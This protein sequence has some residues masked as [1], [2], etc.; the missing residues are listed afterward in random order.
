MVTGSELHEN[1]H[2]EKLCNFSQ[3][4]VEGSMPV[5]GVISVCPSSGKSS[6]GGI[7]LPLYSWARWGGKHRFVYLSYDISLLNNQS[8]IQ[9]EVLQSP[10]WKAAFPEV[11]LKTDKPGRTEF[12]VTGGGARFNTTP[13]SKLTG[14]HF[15]FAVIDDALKAAEALNDAANNKVRDF[16]RS[17]LP[18]RAKNPK[19][20]PVLCIGQRLSLQDAPE[21]FLE[22][23]GIE[24]LFL[25]M[26]FEK[27]SAADRGNS[28]ENCQD[29]RTEP[30]ELMFPSRWGEEEV[31]DLEESLGKA[32]AAAQYAQNPVS[33]GAGFVNDEDVSLVI[34]PDMLRGLTFLNKVSSWDFSAGGKDPQNHSLCVGE[35]WGETRGLTHALRLTG[36]TVQERSI[37]PNARVELERVELKPGVR[38]FVRLAW[39]AGHWSYPQARERFNQVALEDWRNLGCHEH[40]VEAKASGLPILQELDSE[41]YGI[42]AVVPSGSKAE[43]FKMQGRQFRTKSVLSLFDPP[44]Q[45]HWPLDKIL[46]QLL[47][48]PRGRNDDF[49]DTVSQFLTHAQNPV[50]KVWESLAQLAHNRH[51]IDHRYK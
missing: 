10:V 29:P 16:L 35:L 33:E 2:L 8:G 27:N 5:G 49:V 15:D 7:M 44:N 9:I 19:H 13:N 43:R 12:E 45:E 37:N 22:K 48:F 46:K 39:V 30:G 11:S 4:Y 40:L 18:S 17:T 24:H 25:P 41:E 51:L 34:T 3:H 14:R 38:R 23:P 6:V 47:E 28:F 36:S 42:T 31:S 50:S 32:D 20:F 1:W 21:Y 26:R